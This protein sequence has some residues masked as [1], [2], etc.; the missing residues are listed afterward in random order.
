MRWFSKKPGDWINDASSQSPSPSSKG[1]VFLHGMGMPGEG[2]PTVWSASRMLVLGVN[3]AFASADDG[4]LL[5]AG[6]GSHRFSSQKITMLFSPGSG[7]RLGLGHSEA[8]V[9][10][11]MNPFHCTRSHNDPSFICRQHPVLLLI[12]LYKAISR[13]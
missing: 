11:R 9:K 12:L 13:W 5:A 4:G 7:G 6:N 8:V 3:C 10:Q 1:R 2:D